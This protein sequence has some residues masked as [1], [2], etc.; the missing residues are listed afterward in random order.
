MWKKLKIKLKH[1]NARSGNIIIMEKPD[2]RQTFGGYVV[3]LS[4]DP[5][6]TALSHF[7][8]FIEARL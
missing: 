6:I 5:F 4:T 8:L 1:K 3:Y 2:Y 7:A